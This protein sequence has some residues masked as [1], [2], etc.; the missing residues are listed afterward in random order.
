MEVVLSWDHFFL[1]E[2]AKTLGK[3]CFFFE[4]LQAT[5]CII[6]QLEINT[7]P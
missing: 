4:K 1:F 6:T 7:S 5:V 2:N 3:E